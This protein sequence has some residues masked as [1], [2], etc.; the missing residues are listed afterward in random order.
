MNVNNWK[1]PCAKRIFYVL[2]ICIVR[3]ITSKFHIYMRPMYCIYME[4][5]NFYIANLTNITEM[6][7]ILINHILLMK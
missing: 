3:P 2:N 6:V 1:L 4:E 5:T 7:Y